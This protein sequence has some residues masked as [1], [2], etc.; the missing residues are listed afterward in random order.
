MMNDKYLIHHGVKGMK[1]GVRH[2]RQK[3]GM[4]KTSKKK[5]LTQKQKRMIKTGAI[6]V[7][8]ALAIYGSYKLYKFAGSKPSDM[9]TFGVNKPLSEV[10]NQ[11]KGNDIILDNKTKIQRI[12]AD[13]FE[14]LTNKGHTYVSYKF[15]DKKR[16]LTGFRQEMNRTG[17]KDFIHIFKPKENLKIASPETVA[18]EFLNLKPNTTD[19]VFRNVVSPYSI[20]T[21]DPVGIKLNE[22]RTQ[23]FNSLKLKGYNGIIDIEDAAKHA[24][25]KPLILFDPDKFV[26]VSKSRKINQIEVFIAKVLK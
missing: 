15:R 7:G 9:K 10:I 23:L 26:N 16:Y 11:Y 6:V 8:S 12:S 13:S 14:D 2:D 17:S 24:N 25:S 4:Q 19:Q 3:T 5:G 22:M 18:K 20:S 21:D 1:W